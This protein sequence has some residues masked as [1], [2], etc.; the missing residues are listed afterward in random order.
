MLLAVAALFFAG[1]KKKACDT[2]SSKAVVLDQGVVAAD[3]CD[4]VVKLDNGAS[5]H[6]QNLD[7]TYKVNN[8]NVQ[9]C[10]T[11]TSD[12]FVCGWGVKLR[13]IHIDDIQGI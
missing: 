1:C 5:Y 10:Y 12:T 13:V 8:K 7:T 2:N 4:W 3:G 11:L 9:V 6:P